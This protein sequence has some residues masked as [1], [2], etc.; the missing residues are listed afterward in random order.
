[1][2]YVKFRNEERENSLL[3]HGIMRLLEGEDGKINEEESV[4]LIRYGIDHGINYIDTG[5]TY[6]GGNSEVIVG[7]ALKDGYREKVLLA[8]KL[9]LWLVDSE[10]ATGKL[11]DEQLARLDVDCIDM[12]LAHN[13]IVDNWEIMKKYDVI[14]FME[15]QKAAGRIGHIG[16]SFHGDLKLF[17]EVIDAYDWEF[18]QI[19]LNYLDKD[20]QA[21]LEGLAYAR[22]H[23][24]DVIIM[25]P[26]KGGRVT[27]KVPASVQAIWDNAKA[28]GVAP[29]D[30]SPAEWAFRWVAAQPGVVL[31]LSGMNTYS[32]LD[33]NIAIFSKED[34][35][36]MSEAEAAVLD[37][38]AREYNSKIRYQC[39]R[40][41]YCMPCVK[42]LSI[43][44]IITGLNN[45]FAFDKNPSTKMEYLVWQGEGE[46]ASDC[47]GCGECE[48][49]CPQ[50][51]P[52][53]DIMKEAVS[54]FGK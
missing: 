23:G 51:L 46:H 27:D 32:Q 28:S 44:S 21:T 25:E 18:C 43:P 47:I 30:R 9:P 1:M 48:K 20:E 11:L 10:E 36:E 35:G 22:E 33:E 54:E 50:S 38:V 41:G 12:Y 3:G 26:L 17:K 24:V 31:V 37:D 16:F 5:Y 45:W 19:Q 53:T 29:E 6:H 15:E 49:K 4:K 2:K 40:C 34:F 42:G 13:I 8:D 39:T 7:K 52:I 14:G